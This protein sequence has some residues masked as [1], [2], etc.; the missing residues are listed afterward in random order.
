[1]QGTGNA[2]RVLPCDKRMVHRWRVSQLNRLGIL[3][4]LAEEYADRIDWHEVARL[5]R[6][7]CP[8]VLALSIVS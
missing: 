5:V 3:G 6:N 7:G 2:C 4:D 8:P 1:M